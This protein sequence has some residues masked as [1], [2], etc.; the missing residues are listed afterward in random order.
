LL[1]RFKVDR[2]KLI[3]NAIKLKDVIENLSIAKNKRI[4]VQSLQPLGDGGVSKYIINKIASTGMTYDKLKQI[5]KDSGDESLRLCLSKST[6]TVQE[7]QSDSDSDSNFYSESDSDSKQ[8]KCVNYD[9]DS[10]TED[11]ADE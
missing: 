9:W 6:S 8:C 3:N 2:S 4:I 11:E 1:E 10:N 7:C 5:Y